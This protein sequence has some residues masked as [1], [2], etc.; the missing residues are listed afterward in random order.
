MRRGVTV[1]VILLV[2]VLLTGF[3]SAEKMWHFRNHTVNVSDDILTGGFVNATVDVCL[4]DG[5]GIC[6][7]NI[8][9]SSVS[10]AGDYGYIPMWNGTNSLNNSVIFQDGENIGIG[11]TS[12]GSYKFR[13]KNYELRIV[14]FPS[15][16]I[17]CTGYGAS[18]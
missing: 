18:N 16:T 9:S 13:V 2:V 4:K 12:V 15:E 6:L 11:I 7:S 14:V 1:L 17:R 3:V 5:S 8:S 10:G